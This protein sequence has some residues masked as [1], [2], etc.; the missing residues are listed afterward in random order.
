MESLS[1]KNQNVKY[2]LRAIEVFTKYAWV[3]LLKDKKGKTFLSF[4]I[5]IVNESNRKPDKLWVDKSIQFYNKI[6]QEWL[7]NNYILMY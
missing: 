3:I 1:S 5:E 4:F 6:M 7:S 2:L